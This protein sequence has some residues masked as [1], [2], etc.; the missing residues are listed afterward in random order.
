MFCGSTFY[1]EELSERVDGE[2]RNVREE[3][4]SAMNL[5]LERG[6][7]DSESFERRSE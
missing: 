4:E 2:G 3:S 5:K 6:G 1:G 7:E